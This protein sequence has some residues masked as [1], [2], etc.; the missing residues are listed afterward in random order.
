VPLPGT[1]ALARMLRDGIGG[2]V[3]PEEMTRLTRAATGQGAAD[4]DGALRQARSAARVAGRE[5]TAA[6]VLAALDPAAEEQSPARERRIALHECGHAI[7]GTCL[8]LG[9][10]KRVVITQQGGQAWMAYA[11]G[12]QVLE[13]VEAELTYSLAGRAVE[14]LVLVAAA[15]G[16]GGNARSD[17]AHATQTA[18]GI[19]TRMGLG[20]EGPVWLDTSSA[21][22]L[23][24]P[25]KHHPRP[26]PAR[27][28]RSPRP[29]DPRAAARPPDPDGDRPRR[30]GD[31]GGQEAR[32]MARAGASGIAAGERASGVRRHL[33]PP[34]RDREPRRA[35]QEQAREGHAKPGGF[36]R[37][38]ASREGASRGPVK[39]RTVD[40]T[41]FATPLL[42][43]VLDA[44]TLPQQ[45]REVS[46][47]A[48]RSHRPGVAPQTLP[49]CANSRRPPKA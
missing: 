30:G 49:S 31:S 40:H 20:A 13:D 47:P 18:T 41:R 6:D 34:G 46:N 3:P 5:F 39:W 35:G 21:V 42:P 38:G 16:S 4:V 48:P 19:D 26:R 12:E 11:A 28:R 45:R 22:Y 37:R 23:R 17:L 36:L 14:R 25:P 7:V 1:R 44:E 27:G 9:Q 33:Y 32:G 2:E 43:P 24:D 10:I 8:G 29:T 15:A